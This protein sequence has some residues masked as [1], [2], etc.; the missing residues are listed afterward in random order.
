MTEREYIDATNLAKARLA[1]AALASVLPAGPEEQRLVTEA[2]QAM[3]AFVDSLEKRVR[4]E[5]DTTP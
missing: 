4:C 1:L 2:L 5:E 3:R